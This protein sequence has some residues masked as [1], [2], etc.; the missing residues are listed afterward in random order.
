MWV[1][2]TKYIWNKK[3]LVQNYPK[4]K[5]NKQ[6]SICNTET[7]VQLQLTPQDIPIQVY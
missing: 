2:G 4:G 5:A 3:T 1:F 7:P 6:T